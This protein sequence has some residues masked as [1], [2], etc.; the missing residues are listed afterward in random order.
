MDQGNHSKYLVAVVGAGPAGLYAA[1]QLVN[2]GAHV[3]LFNRDIK[4]GGL[5]EYGIYPDKYKM[6]EGLRAQFHQILTSQNL[7]Y[8]GNVQIN[9]NGDMTLAELR[10]MGFQAVLVTVGAQGT[11]WLK[12]PGENLLG[13]YH[14]KDIVYHYNRLPPFS[15]GDFS[16]GKRVAIIGAGN[17]MLDIVHWLSDIVKVERV[18][19]LA[20]RGPAEVKF[21]RS[22]LGYVIG[23]L[24]MTALK[25]ELER[26][27]PLMTSLGQDPMEFWAMVRMVLFKSDPPHSPTRFDMQFLASP[28][29][30]LGDDLGRVSGL[31]IEQNT[32]VKSGD[33]IKPSGSGKYRQMPVDTVIF[34]I[35]DKVDTELGLPSDGHEFIKNPNPHFPIEGTSYEAYDPQSGQ[36]LEGMFLAGWSRKASTGLVGIARR[37]GI[38]GAK[39]V[40]QYLETLPPLETTPE[41]TAQAICERIRC[42]EKPAVGLSDLA[43]LEE[44]ERKEAQARGLVEFKYDNNEEMLD[45]MRL[46]TNV[47]SLISTVE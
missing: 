33:E 40:L 23:Q 6:K 2:D 17:V 15:Y 8:F 32:L 13:V 38:N 45:A 30:I 43:V 11:K 29:R 19:T 10:R 14:A 16:I 47:E 41:E 44:V 22:E 26:V 21:G 28:L 4:P 42:K 12:L 25:A 31:E 39:A 20:R 5:A 34:A 1:K 37:D 18:T 46:N 24:D 9:Q 3:M 27:T 35:G 36:P 7:D